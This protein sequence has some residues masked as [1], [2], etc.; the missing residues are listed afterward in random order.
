[1][2]LVAIILLILVA[3]DRRPDRVRKLTLILFG[4]MVLQ[5]VLAAIGSSVAIVGGLHALSALA[6]AFVA[7]LLVKSTHRQPATP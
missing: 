5:Y 6:V 1:M 7:Y 4:V 2:A 3:I